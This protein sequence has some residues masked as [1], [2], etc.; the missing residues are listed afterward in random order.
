MSTYYG[1]TKKF[2]HATYSDGGY[3]SRDEAVFEV[4]SQ[5]MDDGNWHPP[6]LR[7]KWWQFWRPVEFTDLEKRLVA[8]SLEREDGE[9][10]G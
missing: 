7:E 2:G 10:K 1:F 8:R 4:Y 5:A 6:L 3:S 9:T